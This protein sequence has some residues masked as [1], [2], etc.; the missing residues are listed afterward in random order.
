M[1]SPR[2]ILY[3]VCATEG[4]GDGRERGSKRGGGEGGGEKTRRGK[5]GGQRREAGM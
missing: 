2:V 4:K 1:I 5:E 3:Q